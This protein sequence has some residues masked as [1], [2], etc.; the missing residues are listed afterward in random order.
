MVAMKMTDKDCRD[1]GKAQPALSQLHLCTF[2]AI[3]HK[4]F[5][6][7]FDNLRG[8]IM[9]QRWQCRTTAKNMYF[10][11]FRLNYKL[12]I[13]NLFHSFISEDSFLAFKI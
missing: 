1:F 7:N 6:A 12:S 10:K 8:S 13:T 11:R 2:S 5:L 9:L 4:K 3:Y